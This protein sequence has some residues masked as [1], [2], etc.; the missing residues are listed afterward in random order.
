MLETALTPSLK[1]TSGHTILYM[2]V[3]DMTRSSQNSTSHHTNLKFGLN[4]ILSNILRSGIFNRKGQSK[5]N[6]NLDCE[7]CFDDSVLLRFKGEYSST[8]FLTLTSTSEQLLSS[9]KIPIF[10]A[11]AL[12]PSLVVIFLQIILAMVRN[13]HSLVRLANAVR[14][15]EPNQKHLELL[16]STKQRQRKYCTNKIL[17]S[18]LETACINKCYLP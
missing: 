4:Y 9:I 13:D 1:R 18:N 3:T 17:Y 2:Y 14:R 6:V 7:E 11:T 12:M 5:L 8:D 10:L 16:P 15:S